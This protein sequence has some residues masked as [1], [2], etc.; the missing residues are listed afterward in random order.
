M[1][2]FEKLIVHKTT[3]AS[4]IKYQDIAKLP[5]LVNI[6]VTVREHVSS[7]VLEIKKI[8]LWIEMNNN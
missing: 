4:V 6:G 2:K 1:E 5:I 3:N 7:Q 8:Y